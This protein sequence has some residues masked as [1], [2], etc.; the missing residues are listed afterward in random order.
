MRQES[1]LNDSEL[2]VCCGSVFANICRS[3]HL[4][5]E[6]VEIY[7]VDLSAEFDTSLLLAVH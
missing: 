4:T 3:K 5:G 7:T 2:I 6:S 1:F